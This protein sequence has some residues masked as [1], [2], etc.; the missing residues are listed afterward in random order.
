[1]PFFSAATSVVRSATEVGRSPIVT[2]PIAALPCSWSTNLVE[3]VPQV[4]DGAGR[5][6]A[7]VDQQHDVERLGRRHGAQH[8]AR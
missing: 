7:V 2:I 3:A 5:G 8:L 1:M 6:L 4:G